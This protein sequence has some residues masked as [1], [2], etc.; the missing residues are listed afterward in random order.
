M[1]PIKHIKPELKVEVE[2]DILFNND[3]TLHHLPHELQLDVL[4]MSWFV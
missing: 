4:T 3:Y 2:L 1:L